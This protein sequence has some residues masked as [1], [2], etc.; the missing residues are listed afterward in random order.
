[1]EQHIKNGKALWIA[2]RGKQVRE[3]HPAGRSQGRMRILMTAGVIVAALLLIEAVAAPLWAQ[4]YPN[5]PIRLIL[6]MAPGGPTDILGRT[7]GVRLAEQLGQPVVTENR[8]GAG[9]NLGTELAAKA[10]PDGYT[11][12]LGSATLAIGPSL[13]KKLNYDPIKDFTPISLLSQV[14]MVVLV[15]PSLP[16]KNLKEFVEYAKANPGKLNFGSGG[17]G[18]IS[19]LGCELLKSVAKINIVHV[20]YKGTGPALI[21]LMGGEVSM[22]V[23]SPSAAIPQI[24]SGKAIALAVL[25]NERLPS[26]PNVP[27]AKESGIDLVVT[28]W[29][30]LLAPAGTPR[31]IVDRLSKEWV[32][33]AAMPD[34]KEK[35]QGAGFEPF[36]ST[37]DQYSE[38]LKAETELWAKVIKEANIPKID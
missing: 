13:Y 4:P 3:R 10:K 26:L 30:G 35:M 6:P 21:G 12:V 20:P 28:S 9:G 37:P 27:T 38:F 29:H 32:K 31:N 15:H 8:P 33:I 23:S 22:T 24:Q 19:H 16:V 5:K 1:M 25:G 7:I 36:S 18:A 14:N 34:T 2:K 11:I 17:I